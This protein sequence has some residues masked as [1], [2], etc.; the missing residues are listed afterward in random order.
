VDAIVGLGMGVSLV[1]GCAGIPGARTPSGG[2][3]F[4]GDVQ[5]RLLSA[6]DG[7]MR[8]HAI[9]GVIAGAWV[10]GRGAWVAARGVADVTTGRPLR[11]TDR[12]RIGTI[13]RTFT[14]T[15]LLQ[16]VEEGRVGLDDPVGRYVPDIRGVGAI[17][18][19]QLASNTSGLLDD[20]ELLDP[21]GPA[22]PLRHWSA[23]ELVERAVRHPRNPHVPPGGAFHDASTGFVLLEMVIEQVT[24]NPLGT[25]IERRILRPLGL[26]GT[27]YPIGSALPAPHSQGYLRPPGGGPLRDVT[28]LDPSL[29]RGAGA[30][31]ST[32]A[33]L[34]V[35]AEVL[36]TGRLLRPETRRERLASV[37]TAPGSEDPRYGLGI[38]SRGGLLG[39]SGQIYGFTAA[40]FHDPGR[41]ATIVILANLTGERNVADEILV[42]LL[43]VLFP[44]RFPTSRR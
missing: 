38:A 30:M 5:Q 14:T 1:A 23:R 16:L 28:I 20:E 42:G 2:P 32:L 6:I 9:P 4:P 25:E 21:A 10:P 27:V 35:W 15:V 33:D 3:P 24:G 41:K 43:D 11:V 44:E 8:S 26:R 29:V 13:T 22:E 17:T 19:R 34:E 18:L 12:M 39:H 36:A 37:P 7:V 31:I 40:M